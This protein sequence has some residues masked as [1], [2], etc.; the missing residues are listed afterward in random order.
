[1]PVDISDYIDVP[2]RIAEFRTRYPNGSLRPADPDVP[3]RIE[4]MGE[5][6]YIA[7]VAAAYRGPDDPNPGIGMA[8][9]VVPGRTP[10]TRGSELQNAETSAWGR[11][12]VAALVADTRKGIASQEEVR[13]R[14]AE[15]DEEATHPTADQL[16]RQIRGVADARDI[17][18]EAIKQDFE[19][20]TGE[21]IVVTENLSLLTGYLNDL[22][23]NGMHAEPTA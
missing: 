12:I 2:T 17:N 1:M 13:N 19:E 14:A 20:R 7:V 16:R 10:Y 21:D 8:Y 5:Q 6:W 22:R 3:Y 23:A 11:A 4:K 9:E 15:R 18:P